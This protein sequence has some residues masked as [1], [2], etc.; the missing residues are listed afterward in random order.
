MERSEPFA[1]VRELASRWDA[2]ALI[3]VLGLLA[4]FAEA[5]RG[6]LEP[7]TRLQATPLSL[8]PSM[9]PVYA[10]RTTLRMFVAMALS[11]LFTFT[12]GT[13][14]A[15][16][17]RAER[18]L[19]PIL[20][21]LQSVPILGFL[22]V[23]VVFFLSLVPGRVLGAEFAAIFAIFTSQAWN[24]AFSFY[25]SLR[26]VPEELREACD[27][28]HLTPWMRFWRLETPFAMPALLW[29]M[30]MS[31]SGSWFFVVASEAI[32]VGHTDI[33]LPGVGSYIA[34]AIQH[35][36]LSAIGWAIATMLI[37]ILLYDQLIFRPLIVWGDRF[38]IDQEQGG[39]VPDSWALTMMQ[40]SRLVG[41]V[42]A[43][44]N[45]LVRR[46]NRRV[47]PAPSFASET[48]RRTTRRGDALWFALLV[49]LV[50]LAAWRIAR[51]LIS[52]TSVREALHAGGL[53]CLTL[54]RVVVLIA[55]ASIVWVPVGVWVGL[56]PRAAALVQPVAQFLAAFPSNLLF[57]VVV[58]GIL[59]FR[60]SPDLWLSP[61][62][63]LGTQ[64]YILFNVIAG[65]SAMPVEL[66]YASENF[67]V[68]GRLWWRKVA[69]PSVLPY[70]VTGAITASG[71]AWNASVVAEVVS[72]GTTQLRAHGLGAYIADATSAGDFHRVLLGITTMSL[73]VVVVNRIFWRPLYYYAERKYRLT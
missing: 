50:A 33:A 38:R 60:L 8:A 4:F 36:S 2:I 57:P 21:I 29:N 19:V 51:S 9:L 3:V 42:T 10:A 69:L 63:I 39:Q 16:S 32:S 47:G 41:A 65:A 1:F 6:L 68:R 17:E 64:W 49:L 12:Y 67:G 26:T 34:L 30:M 5:S 66:R 28:F 27:S 23:T 72:W 11:L 71:G 24:M 55:L 37:V 62:M 70:Y 43:L 13:W 18:I 44:F 14:A 59:T 61:L 73:F 35:R 48:V 53:A 20:D 56:R 22:S 54:L 46:F 45:S 15:K 40:R 7:L 52:E 58:Y 31:M 25:Q